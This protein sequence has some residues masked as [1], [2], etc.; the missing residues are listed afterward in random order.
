MQKLG[1]LMYEC[2]YHSWKTADCS[3]PVNVVAIKIWVSPSRQ[4]QI[5]PF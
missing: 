2:Q 4:L 5:N 3:N 1:G